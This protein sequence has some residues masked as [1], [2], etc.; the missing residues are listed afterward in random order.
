MGESLF[1]CY[2][3]W[4][5]DEGDNQIGTGEVHDENP[6]DRSRVAI[7]D[8]SAERSNDKQIA[9]CTDHRREAD[10]ADVGQRESRCA[11]Q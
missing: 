10:D 11:Q 9:E 7:T 8:R 4:I 6:A 3:H 5:N 1:T 2:G